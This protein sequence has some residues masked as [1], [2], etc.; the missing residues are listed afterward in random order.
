M[1]EPAG[2][3]WSLPSPPSIG[4]RAMRAKGTEAASRAL[5]DLWYD[6]NSLPGGCFSVTAQLYSRAR[7]DIKTGDSGWVSP[8]LLL[9]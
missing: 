9:P 7:G 4:H 6:G 2:L 5:S 3:C 1:L 8:N